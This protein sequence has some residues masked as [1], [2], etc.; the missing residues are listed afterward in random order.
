MAEVQPGVA[1]LARAASI[2]HLQHDMR[3]QYVIVAGRHALAKRPVQQVGEDSLVPGQV[4][5]LCLAMGDRQPAAIE[6]ALDERIARS[7]AV[8]EVIRLP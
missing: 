4:A 2:A 6:P 8:D 3:H 7:L 1:R 5:I